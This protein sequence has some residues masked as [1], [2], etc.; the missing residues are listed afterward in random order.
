MSNY[1]Q[2]RSAGIA[3]CSECDPAI[4]QWHGRFKKRTADGMLVDQ[5]HG[6]WMQ[7]QIDAGQLPDEYKIVGVA[8]E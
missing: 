3:L 6:L 1:W 7:S 5:Y 8:G 4:G 2:T